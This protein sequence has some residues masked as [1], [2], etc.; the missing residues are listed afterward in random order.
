MKFYSYYKEVYWVQI[1]EWGNS[2]WQDA[3]LHKSEGA[4]EWIAA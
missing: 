1:L 3:S 2:Y 4:E